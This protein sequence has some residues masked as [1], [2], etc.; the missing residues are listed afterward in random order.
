[1]STFG[2]GSLTSKALWSSHWVGATLTTETEEDW[3][4]YSVGSTLCCCSLFRGDVEDE[5]PS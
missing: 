3:G 2:G 1:M 5:D 4:G